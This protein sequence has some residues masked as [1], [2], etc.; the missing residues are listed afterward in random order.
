MRAFIYTRVSLDRDG[1]K[2]S[3]ETQEAEC[4]QLCADKGWEVA[5]VFTDRNASAFK[6]G[7]KR[8]EFDKM[9]RAL[10][11]GE[12]DMLVAYKLDRLTRGGMVGLS[13]L[14]TK[15]EDAKAGLITV[16]DNI[17]A[18]TPIGQGVLGIIASLAQQE[19][20]NTATRV[21]SAHE[22]AAK[23]GKMHS[24]GSRQFGYERDGTI[25]PEEAAVAHEAAT[26]LLAGESL[27]KVAY[28]LNERGIKTTMGKQWHSDTLS[29]M[30]RS[31]R[32]VG[33]RIHKGHAYP[34]DWTPILDQ[35]TWTDLQARLNRYVAHKRT[36]ERHL[37]TG[38]ICC[39]LC[40][41][42]L[43][44]L[45][46]PQKDGTRFSRYQCVRQPGYPNC[47]K[48]AITKTTTDLWVAARLLV[49]LTKTSMTPLDEAV[50]FR[51]NLEQEIEKDQQALVNLTNDYYV[52]RRLTDAEFWPAREAIRVRLEG[53]QRQLAMLGDV[54]VD[55]LRPGNTD[56]LIGWWE[57]L[58]LPEQRAVILANISKIRI[59]PAKHRGGN[60]Y[61]TDRVHIEWT[62]DLISRALEE[63]AG[64]VDEGGNLY[65]IEIIV[66]DE[67]IA[68]GER[69]A[70]SL[71]GT[72]LGRSMGLSS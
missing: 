72:P 6:K 70:A 41:S 69:I 10:K 53:N 49:F 20:L 30:L 19:S 45:Q 29:Q 12:A 35:Q 47:G 33:L 31:P 52:E 56:D 4:R 16:H 43:K 63:T 46:M 13:N 17:D 68:E 40:D 3:P 54:A 2:A 7:A 34:G 1:T 42:H 48:I 23:A 26:R 59:M 8:P 55:Q 57:G 15:L 58:T 50:Q 18:S 32:L 14:L 5:G 65:T 25:R 71:A 38:V 66:E 37:L 36:V 28:D 22:R 39:G 44:T 64:A 62:I 11:A 51:A 67:D 60:K 21:A 27:H 61:D 24:G 9:L